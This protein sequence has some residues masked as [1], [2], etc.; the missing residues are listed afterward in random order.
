MANQQNDQ[1]RVLHVAGGSPASSQGSP[2]S[3]YDV[4]ADNDS[5]VVRAP[6]PDASPVRAN[7]QSR[8]Y[9]INS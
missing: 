7:T 5:V 6:A 9:T 8:T 2:R 4:A 1:Q 3:R